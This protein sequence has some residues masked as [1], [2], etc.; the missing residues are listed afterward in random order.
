MQNI[1]PPPET[2]GVSSVAR[3]VPGPMTHETPEQETDQK[4]TS[5]NF[6]KVFFGLKT[7]IV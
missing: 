3:L 1:D 2:Q 6:P 7:G 5:A 4:R